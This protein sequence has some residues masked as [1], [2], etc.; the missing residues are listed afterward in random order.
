MEDN[1][2]YIHLDLIIQNTYL[3]STKIILMSLVI[4]LLKGFK[5]SKVLKRKE[6][7]YDKFN[8]EIRDDFF[9]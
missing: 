2:K 5:N 6:K 7:V 9:T 8:L 1:T 4:N 3:M